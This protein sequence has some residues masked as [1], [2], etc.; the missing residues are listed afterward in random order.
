[1]KARPS[2]SSK[3]VTETKVHHFVADASDLRIPPGEVHSQLP[4]T[5]GN[6]R[7]FI[8]TRCLPDRVVYKQAAGCIRLTVFN[9]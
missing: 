8:C 4:T 7:A 1:M 6:G 2:V 5:M 9:A 3:Q